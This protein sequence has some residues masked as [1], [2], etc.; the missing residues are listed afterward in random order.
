M[1]EKMQN[2][3]LTCSNKANIELREK[4]TVNAHSL[5]FSLL[6]V[7]FISDS[8]QQL[9]NLW[10]VPLVSFKTGIYGIKKSRIHHTIMRRPVASLKFHFPGQTSDKLLSREYSLNHV[11]LP[12]KTAKGINFKFIR[13][14]PE[15]ETTGQIL[16]WCEWCWMNTTPQITKPCKV[17]VRTHPALERFWGNHIPEQLQLLLLN[18]SRTLWVF[19]L[20][21][22][23]TTHEW[24][25]FYSE[26]LLGNILN[27]N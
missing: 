10:G 25:P 9:F 6:A 14:F 1:R 20:C 3:C 23:S 7:F 8:P 26:Y 24:D 11:H 15:T 18:T 27:L 16:A 21:N 5:S 13:S 17:R 2:W 12:F 4:N 19:C 22:V